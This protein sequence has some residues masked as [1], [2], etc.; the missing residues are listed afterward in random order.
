MPDSRFYVSQKALIQKRDSVL[1]LFD[2]I[3][4]IDFPGGKI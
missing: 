4:G 2:P 3:E 1:V